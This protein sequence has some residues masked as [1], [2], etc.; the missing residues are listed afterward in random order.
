MVRSRPV[1]SFGLLPRENKS[2]G[3][4]YVAAS[5]QG[6]P[7]VWSDV[8]QKARLCPLDFQSAAPRR[9]NDA[10]TQALSAALVL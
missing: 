9:G 10:D 7:P 1:D 6:D 8:W 5:Q 4:S 2:V 3:D